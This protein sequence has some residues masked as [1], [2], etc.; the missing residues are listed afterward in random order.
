MVKDGVLLKCA[1]GEENMIVSP[2]SCK[3]GGRHGDRAWLL[4]TVLNAMSAS[5]A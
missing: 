5:E 1:P 2:E 4:I 3:V